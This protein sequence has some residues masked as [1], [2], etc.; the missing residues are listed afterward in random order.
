MTVYHPGGTA[1]VIS[2]QW[3]RLSLPQRNNQQRKGPRPGVPDTGLS[4]EA[5]VYHPAEQTRDF[6]RGDR[7]SIFLGVMRRKSKLSKT[8]RK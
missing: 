4:V 6:N 1:T 8:V 5:A 7:I 3:I 2:E